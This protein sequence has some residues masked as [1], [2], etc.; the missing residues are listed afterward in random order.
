MSEKE[1][2]LPQKIAAIKE[3]GFVVWSGDELLP[4]FKDRFEA[5]KVPVIGIRHVR[6]WGIQVDDERELPGHERTTIPDEELW[7]V[8]LK[9]KDGSTYEVNSNMVEPAPE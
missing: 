3:R 7:Q 2:A 5:G 9:A 4:E 6:V 1:K 8:E